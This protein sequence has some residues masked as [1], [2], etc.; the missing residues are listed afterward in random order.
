MADLSD[1]SQAIVDLIRSVIY[2]DGLNG[3]TVPEVPVKIYP[4]W[5]DPKRIED[6]LGN[7]D[8]RQE[9]PARAYHVSVFNLPGERNTDRYPSTWLEKPSEAPTYRLVV[10]GQAI[11]VEG[12]APD[13][14]R[15]Q[16]IAVM[17][18]PKVY[19][20]TTTAGQ[21][22]NQVAAALGALIAED[23]PGVVVNGPDITVPPLYRVTFARVGGL[24]SASREVGRQEKSFQITIWTDTPESRTALA[25]QLHPVFADTQF[26][27]LAD[28]TRARFVH[29]SATDIDRSQ[30]AG[31]YRRDFVYT[32]EYATTREIEA[33]QIVAA[34]TELT[35]CAGETIA[36]TIS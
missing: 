21:L 29:K 16:N 36:E 32:V 23:V 11:T 27:D 9:G 4:G 5:P 14:F 17:V 26:L 34:Q 33:A 10:N 28:G 2:P 31:A 6:D 18:F 13:P 35:N 15:A 8:G 3:L 1:A 30:R 24:G 22:P 25:R 7:R 19:T 20:H 12:A